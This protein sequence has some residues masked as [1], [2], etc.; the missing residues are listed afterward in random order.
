MERK[1]LY[2]QK[3]ASVTRPAVFI[4]GELEF[5]EGNQHLVCQDIAT[6]LSLQALSEKLLHDLVCPACRENFDPETPV[7]ID[8]QDEEEED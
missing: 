1:K 7:M 5:E 3:L 2:R 8:D 6:R 4:A